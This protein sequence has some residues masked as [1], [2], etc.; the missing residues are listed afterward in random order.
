M[1]KN[2]GSMTPEELD[3]FGPLVSRLGEVV[4]RS[5]MWWKLRRMR[6]EERKRLPSRE[7][8]ISMIHSKHKEAKERGLLH[9]ER[10]YNVSLYVFVLDYDI[11]V[12][13]RHYAVAYR[14]WEKRFTARQLAVIL[15]E[16]AEDLPQL[17]GKEFRT[18][19]RALP[20]WNNADEELKV[21]SGKLNTF[22]RSNHRLLKQLR[23]FAGA[24][25]DRDAGKQMEVIENIDPME[26]YKL[27]A[28]LYVGL[29]LLLT[30]LLRLVEV[31]GKTEVMLRH[32]LNTPEFH[33]RN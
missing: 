30:F 21:I 2:L 11:A 27:A 1:S 31:L 5:V 9:Y 8:V 28:E 10:I 15:Y 26:I 23:S 25:R 16:S 7:K 6:R 19:L 3:K 24:H 4:A 12:I 18:T 17:L 29:N 20:L 14:T 13:S 32:I 22:L 33:T